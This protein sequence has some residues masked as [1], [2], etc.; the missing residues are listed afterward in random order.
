MTGYIAV[1]STIIH[2]P[3]ERVWKALIDPEEI[4]RY[5]MGARVNTDWKEGSPITWI[6]E[7]E[8]H[9]YVDNGTV[10]V[11]REPDLLKYTH[12][13]GSSGKAAE[14]TVTIELKEVAGVTHLRLSQD[15]NSTDTQREAAEEKWGRMLDQLKAMLGEAP[16]PAPEA[17]RN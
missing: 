7:W 6:G 11:V 3:I 9:Q 8:G 5:M 1:V 4:Q 13:S 12:T 2:H 15:G 17:P 10:L 16:V 14:H